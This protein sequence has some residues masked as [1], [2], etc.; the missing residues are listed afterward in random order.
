MSQLQEVMVAI[1]TLKDSVDTC[2]TVIDQ[3]R[4]LLAELEN[5]HTL[6]PRAAAF[7]Q[8]TGALSHS[9]LMSRLIPDVEFAARHDRPLALAILDIDNFRQI[10]DTFGHRFGDD[11]LFAVG[12]RLRCELQENDMLGRLEADRFAIVW[13]GFTSQQAQNALERILRVVVRDPFIIKPVDMPALREQKIQL[14]MRAGLAVCPD[15]GISAS[16]LLLLAEDALNRS[17]NHS[18][19][20]HPLRTEPTPP[21][22]STREQQRTPLP[23]SSQPFSQPATPLSYIDVISRKHS[24]IQALTSALEAHDP[25]G[26]SKAHD[27]AELAEDTAILLGRSV[28]E[29]CLVGLGALLHDVG[30]L[31]IPADILSKPTPLTEEEWG[32]IRKHPGL[33]ERLLS[34]IGGV[35]AAVASIVASHRERWDGTGYPAGIA[36]EAIPLGSRIVA[37]CDVYD[38]LISKRPYRSAFNIEDAIAELRRGA[39]TQFD[40]E[41]VEAFIAAISQ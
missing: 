29:A 3:Q 32:F 28:E 6:S 10:N 17:G 33:G 31:G 2:S 5:I 20:P 36:G 22:T 1:A 8:L 26:L 15:D 11:V 25:S 19:Y 35:L 13:S 41:V 38:A 4:Q 24:S 27:L 18:S 30:N 9:T 34:S 16:S 40:P 14:T 21:Y 37:L 7:D 23:P 39:G 12:E